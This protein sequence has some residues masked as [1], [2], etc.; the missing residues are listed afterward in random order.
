MKVKLTVSSSGKWSLS[1]VVSLPET[2]LHVG[3]KI[4][5]DLGPGGIAVYCVL[6]EED[7][8]KEGSDIAG[9]E[10]SITF[11]GPGARVVGGGKSYVDD[12]ELFA[13]LQNH[14]WA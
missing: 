9:W 2:I 13:E 1:K 8:L 5:L 12:N 11:S 7:D 14:G 10:A 6:V 4:D 3:S